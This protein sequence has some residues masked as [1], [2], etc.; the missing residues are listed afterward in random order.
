MFSNILKI[1]QFIEYQFNHRLAYLFVFFF[2]KDKETYAQNK[3]DLIID[4]LTGYKRKGFY[5]DVGANNPDV[6]SVTKKFY[7]RGWNGINVE[8]DHSNY[9]LL[10]EK[11]KRDINLNIGIANQEGELDFFM[12]DSANT[13]ES[14]GF[15]FSKQV[16]D[17]RKY[18]LDSKKVQVLPL[19]KV[20]AENSVENIDF[21]NID[22]EGFEREVIKSNDWKKYRPTVLCIEGNNYDELLSCHNYERILFDGNNVYYVLKKNGKKY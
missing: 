8:P 19:K 21:M 6:I 17:K 12:K 16:Y 20:F 18:K 3:E 15:T 14:T 5:V 13:T 9:L 4:I 2:A 10:E 22:V 1:K 11:R 7:E